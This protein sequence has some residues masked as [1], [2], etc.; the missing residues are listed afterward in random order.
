MHLVIGDRVWSAHTLDIFAAGLLNILTEIAIHF[1]DLL[2]FHV[3][4]KRSA[5]IDSETSQEWLPE[6]VLLD[7]LVGQAPENV[8]QAKVFLNKFILQFILLLTNT[9]W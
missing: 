9:Q 1:L 4:A 6:G 2:Y 8:S 3:N 7:A 5:N